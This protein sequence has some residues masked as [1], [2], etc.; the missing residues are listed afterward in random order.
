MGTKAILTQYLKDTYKIE[1]SKDYIIFGIRGAKPDGDGNDLTDSKQSPN[2]FDDTIGFINIDECQVFKG[3]VDAGSKYTLAPMDKNGCFHLYN[4]LWLAQRAVHM[5]NNAFNL[6]GKSLGG[7]DIY[8]RVGNLEGWRDT[9]KNFVNDENKTYTDAT[10]V[11]IH[12][13]SGTDKIDGWSAGCQ[14]LRGNWNSQD[15]KTFR[16]TLYASKQKVYAYCLLDFKELD[17]YYK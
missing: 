8:K 9:N 17:K 10:G 3:T 13:G 4:G 7:K 5:G 6:F 14:V 16:D 12:A 11:D 15:W 1:L 2:V